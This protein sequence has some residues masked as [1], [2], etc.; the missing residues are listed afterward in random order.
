VFA[1]TTF[2]ITK[3]LSYLKLT[4]FSEILEKVS[5]KEKQKSV[6]FLIFPGKKNDYLEKKLMKLISNYHETS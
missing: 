3:G 2:R 4:P 5:E 1:K 6:Y